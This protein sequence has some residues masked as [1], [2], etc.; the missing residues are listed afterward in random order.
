MT[1]ALFAQHVGRLKSASWRRWRKRKILDDGLEAKLRQ[2]GLPLIPALEFVR[3]LSP[4][5]KDLPAM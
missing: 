5:Y 4:L 2:A 3:D 1:R